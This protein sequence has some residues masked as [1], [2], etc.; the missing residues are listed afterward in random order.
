M[1]AACLLAGCAALAGSH[2]GPTNTDDPLPADEV[3]SETPPGPEYVIGL[4]DVLSISVW[5]DQDLTGTVIV[6][7]DGTITFPLVGSLQAEGK[8]VAQLKSD[9]AEKI[10]RYV[11]DPTLTVSVQQIHSMQVYV[12][13]KVNRP[14]SYPLRT[15]LNVLQAL[16]IAGGLNSFAD[17]D[18][19]KIVRK[20]NGQTQMLSFEYDKVT[21]GEALGQNIELQR[22]DIVVVP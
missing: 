18:Q 3:G 19:I 16:S 9:L 11:P 22:G 1:G 20:E 6:L 21:Q 14:G 13:G 15:D 4:G 8:T 2:A 12:I 10:D 5:R 7:P 17:R